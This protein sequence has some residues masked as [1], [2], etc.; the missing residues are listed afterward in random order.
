[1]R[2]SEFF[3]EEAA[4]MNPSED[5]TLYLLRRQR[6]QAPAAR[7]RQRRWVRQYPRGQLPW[8]EPGGPGVRLRTAERGFL[9]QVSDRAFR[10]PLCDPYRPW[11]HL[12]CFALCLQ[13]RLPR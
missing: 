7:D 13:L 2:F 9:Q 3:A 5:P 4:W 10:S 6:H 8:C 1:L 12:L 11:P